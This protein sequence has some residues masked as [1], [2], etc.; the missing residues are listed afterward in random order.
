MPDGTAPKKAKRLRA[1]G[2]RMQIIRQ[3]EALENLTTTFNVT[4]KR[5]QGQLITV[6]RKRLLIPPTLSPPL[7]QKKNPFNS[8]KCKEIR[9]K[10]IQI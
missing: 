6:C 3:I 9:R 2:V 5:L 8:I 10:I 4:L 1:I 7:K